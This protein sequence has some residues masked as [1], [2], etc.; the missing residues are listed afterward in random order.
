MELPHGSALGAYS[1]DGGKPLNFDL[2]GLPGDERISKF[3]QVFF[4]TSEVDIGPHT[5]TVTFLGSEDTT[6]LTLDRLYINNGTLVSPPNTTSITRT[7]PSPTTVTNSDLGKA[8]GLNVDALLGGIIGGL[9]LLIII[10]GAFLCRRNRRFSRE[11]LVPAFEGERAS[12]H[13]NPY[14]QFQTNIGPNGVPTT[15]IPPLIPSMKAQE[16]YTHAS[17]QSLPF[18][19]LSAKWREA[20]GLAP[21]PADSSLLRPDSFGSSSLRSFSFQGGDNSR[22][23]HNDS[24]LYS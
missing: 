7:I 3:N 4:T 6:P 19:S 12:M 10:A 9:G 23:V 20:F 8:S 1:I 17:L 5:L 2:T 24:A 16:T 21:R 18:K 13:F 11:T 22:R 14:S 15:P